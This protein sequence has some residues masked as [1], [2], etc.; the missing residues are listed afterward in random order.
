M[1]KTK[2][3][4]LVLT[5]ALLVTQFAMLGSVPASAT[6]TTIDDA[7][8][9]PDYA[10]VELS[11]AG[12]KIS[13]GAQ[14]NYTA[15]NVYTATTGGSVDM[16]AAEQIEFDIY[17]ADYAAFASAVSG[18]ALRFYVAS[19]SGRYNNRRAYDFDTQITASGWN[20]I[21]LGKNDH[22]SSDSTDFTAI[23]WVGL[24]FWN[25][26]G[27][28]NPIGSTQVRIA[29]IC[30]SIK[31]I[32]RLPDVP[33]YAYMVASREG[34]TKSWGD[35]YNYTN[36]RVYIDLSATPVDMDAA[37]LIEF[38]IYIKDYTA[39]ASAVD[40]KALR[41][42]VASGS[43]QNNNRRVYDFVTQITKNGWN[44][45][46]LGRNNHYSSD[47]CSFSA[48]KYIGLAFWNGNG[49][50]NPIASTEV[51]IANVCA[52]LKEINRVPAYPGNAAVEIHRDG[53]TYENVAQYH[54]LA[55]KTRNVSNI[56]ISSVDQIEFD[57]YI[58]DLTAF[59]NQISGHSL[60]FVLKTSGD[61]SHRA[62][63]QFTLQVVNSGWNHIILQK[64][65]KDDI[66]ETPNFSNVTAYYFA[67]WNDSSGSP[68]NNPNAS[69]VY[70][71]A[72]V[73]GTNV[74]DYPAYEHTAMYKLSASNYW[75]GTANN[76]NFLIGGLT[77]TDISATEQV[78]FDV[79]VQ[80]YENYASATSGG[81]IR[82]RFGD[83]ND[84]YIDLNVKSKITHGGWN[85][86]AAVWL[87]SSV[88]PNTDRYTISNNNLDLTAIKWIKFYST[89]GINWETVGKTRFANVCFTKKATYKTHSVVLA[90][91]IGLNFFMDLSK[92]NAEQKT[93]SYMTF[94]VANSDTESRAEYKSDFTNATGAYHGFTCPLSSVQ[95]AEIV[96]PTFH[97]GTG[98]TVTGAP[99]SVKDYI[100]YVAANSGNFPDAVVDLVKSLGDYGYYAQIYLGGRNGWTAGTQYTAIGKYRAA[101]YGSDDYTAKATALSSDAVDKD[102]DGTAVTGLS[103]SLNFD[104]NTFV[105]VELHTTDSLF[106][107]ATV[108]GKTLYLSSSGKVRTQGLPILKLGTPI[109]I[110]GRGNA[111]ATTFTVKL[112]GLSYIRAILNSDS[113]TAEAKNAVSALYDYY[114]AARTYM[115]V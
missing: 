110:T 113:T 69:T 11:K 35:K 7:P 14:Y 29:N 44:H 56:N 47:S 71:I 51:R 30:A 93:G 112:S 68:V 75:G 83:A 13:W 65:A 114:K 88:D 97:Y 19:G 89:V 78:E 55:D 82:F 72:N 57:L 36:D 18:K 50:A 40:G 85:H 33:D 10:L 62:R 41:F 21:I 66:G 74:S 91:N 60:Y 106:A 81:E 54:Y 70:R 6:G 22:Y 43:N 84:Y 73:C 52:A 87:P 28:S 2:I 1:K 9:Y 64:D 48:I 102:I 45:I 101:D 37:E 25:G 24:A 3:F 23:K 115:G 105:N 103:Y 90:D 94:A 67:F 98:E 80:N 34:K 39:F 16:S 76:S 38:D 26:S 77:P 5:L 42:Y 58:G 100:D 108:D 46:I 95:M 86:V 59:R 111:N 104:S 20:H 31:E 4:A 12:K 17:I 53:R 49:V 27:V 61:S 99:F 92:L 15:D 107:S 32:N 63:Y 79:F 8:A 109:E 96:T